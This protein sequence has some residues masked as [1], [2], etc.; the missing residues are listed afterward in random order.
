MFLSQNAKSHIFIK[1]SMA[2]G[3]HDKSRVIN[4]LIGSLDLNRCGDT[5]RVLGIILRTSMFELYF[6]HEVSDDGVFKGFG[7]EVIGEK[8]VGGP[9]GLKGLFLQF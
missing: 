2:R 5:L 9:V 8:H 7:R 6:G 3:E 4:L 1:P